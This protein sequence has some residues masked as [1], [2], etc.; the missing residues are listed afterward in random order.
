VKKDFFA[1][2]DGIARPGATFATN[3]SYLDVDEIASATQRPA[4]VVGLHFFSPAQVM[5]LLEIVRGAKTSAETLATALA[6]GRKIRKLSVVARV[7]E[8]FIGNRIYAAYRRQCE[9]MVEE[10][11]Y[12]EEVDAAL[13]AFG[14]AMGPFAVADMAGLDIGWRTRQRLAAT[15][16]P[17]DRYV[18]IADRICEL[19]RFGQ[20]TG[21][22]WYRY[23]PGAR[24]GEPDPQV[25]ALIDTASAAKGI[26]RRS[27]GADEI[28]R[29]ALLTMVNESA[30]LLAEGIAQR[31]SDVDLVLV[32]GYGF[33]KHEGG[34]LFWATRQPRARLL[35]DLDGVAA[36]SGHGFRRGDL[37]AALPAPR[38][39]S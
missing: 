31:A 9:F 21:A 5:R 17:R 32:N 39:K 11:A 2:I 35:A 28:R 10:G 7:G 14:F 12:P 15:R 3:T 16:D 6:V 4:D 33:P 1:K 36:A 18:E 24:K 13:E 30:L 27:F 37:A 29:R 25:R 34:A 26:A 19:G 38:E 8:G 22:G 23:A 20:K